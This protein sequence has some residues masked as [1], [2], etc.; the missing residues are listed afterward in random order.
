VN[1]KLA[2]A[3]SASTIV[4]AHGIF[5]HLYC[6]DSTV[7]SWG[8]VGVRQTNP[9]KVKSALPLLSTREFLRSEMEHPG[10]VRKG[11]AI[12]LGA[13]KVDGQAARF[14]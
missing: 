14:F 8:R 5:F 4:V 11:Q 12:R 3:A 7:L 2:R 9:S 10:S 13:L 6:E 1:R